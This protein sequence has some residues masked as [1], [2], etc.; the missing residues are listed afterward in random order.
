MRVPLP[1]ESTKKEKQL[2]DETRAERR[3]MTEGHILAAR[4]YHLRTH[5]SRVVCITP[6]LKGSVPSN[7]LKLSSVRMERYSEVFLRSF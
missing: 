5:P 7:K 1:G 4:R 6:I 3:A 2:R